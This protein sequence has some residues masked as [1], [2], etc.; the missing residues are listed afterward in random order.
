MKTREQLFSPETPLGKFEVA[1]RKAWCRQTA[2]PGCQED[3]TDVNPAFGQCAVTL[4][5]LMDYFPGGKVL[6]SSG[7]HHYAYFLETLGDKPVDLTS[8]QFSEGVEIV[9]DGESDR[10]YLL[11]SAGAIKANT[12]ERY[13]LLADIV[14]EIIGDP[15]VFWASENPL[16]P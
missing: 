7:H 6:R 1:V 5:V 4:L 13:I 16:E 15:N 12:L 11:E 3:W 8:E 10:T 2:Y 9:F 14:A